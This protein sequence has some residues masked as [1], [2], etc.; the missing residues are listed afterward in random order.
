[1]S[2]L[3]RYERTTD[4]NIVFT[5]DTTIDKSIAMVAANITLEHAK[6]L[7]RNLWHEN[8]GM[9]WVTWVVFNFRRQ[10]G[11]PFM[12]CK[13]AMMLILIG[14]C[15]KWQTH[16]WS[17]TSIAYKFNLFHWVMT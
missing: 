5:F 1:M 17:H 7:I 13:V 4:I 3:V 8:K 12:E 11:A 16:N 6:R 10:S 9:L 14:T 15:V 2:D